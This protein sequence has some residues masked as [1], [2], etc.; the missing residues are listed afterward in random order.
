MADFKFALPLISPSTSWFLI[1]AWI[2]AVE[3]A[4]HHAVLNGLVYGLL[5]LVNLPLYNALSNALVWGP[6]PVINGLYPTL[7][8]ADQKKTWSAEK[9]IYD[10]HSAAK[11]ALTVAI[12]ASIDPAM[13]QIL[14]HPANGC[15]Q[16][17]V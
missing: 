6:E 10:A 4:A 9:H 2:D 15:H 14:R 17:Y 8:N 3:N 16:L 12:W 5:P 7:G 1:R 11:N 13:L